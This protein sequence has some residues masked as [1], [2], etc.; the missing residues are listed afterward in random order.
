MAHQPSC[1][2]CG[3]PRETCRCS[4]T[5]RGVQISSTPFRGLQNQ[6]VG[7]FNGL[8]PTAL[9]FPTH[10]PSQLPP[11]PRRPAFH[12]QAAHGWPSGPNIFA[13]LSRQG[14]ISAYPPAP[15]PPGYLPA[16]Q[17]LPFPQASRGP[18]TNQGGTSASAAATDQTTSNRT[19]GK[20][21]SK[22][23]RNTS[24]TKRQPRTRR[25]TNAPTATVE[26]P[27]RTAPE[28]AKFVPS[29]PS[30]T[31]VDIKN[32]KDTSSVEAS[33]VWWNV[34][35]L[36]SCDLPAEEPLD[37]GTRSKKRPTSEFVGCRL[38]K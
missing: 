24:T 27:S 38:C 35:L 36:S 32:T 17:H 15:F 25:K 8:S 10:F 16:G 4:V 31:A 28:G 37:D 29:D 13:S 33:D 5:Q 7:F 34:R 1:T 19:T 14:Y 20:T 12:T 30:L 21:T 23:A 3:H 6:N 9:R 22:R 11:T 2:L 26:P 18:E